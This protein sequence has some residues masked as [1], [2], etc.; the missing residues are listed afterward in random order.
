MNFGNDY[1]FQGAAS[2]LGYF[3]DIGIWVEGDAVKDVLMM[4]LQIWQLFSGE[5]ATF[6]LPKKESLQ[7]DSKEVS[8]TTLSSFPRKFPN[9]IRKS[10]FNAVMNAKDYI[11][12]INLYL[13]DSGLLHEL[14]EARKRGVDVHLVSTFIP[15]PG[16][17][18]WF[19]RQLYKGYF[20]LIFH[21]EKLQ[22]HGVHLHHYTKYNVHAKVGMVDN[23][24]V[25]IGSSNLDYSSLRNAMEINVSLTDSEFIK[26]LKKNLFD[27]DFKESGTLDKKLPFFKRIY[28]FICYCTFMVAEKY[29]I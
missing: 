20:Y 8:L 13:T 15:T 3:H 7:S 18:S 5:T 16:I 17:K 14:K 29:F 4:Y 6:S 25:T 21:K 9:E 11:Y 19:V 27:I 23:N 1:L 26:T 28:Y 10:Y 24:W 12:I 22:D 2:E